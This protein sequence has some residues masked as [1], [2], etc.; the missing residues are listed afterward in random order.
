MP[1]VIG[2]GGVVRSMEV[3][4]TGEEQ[5]KLDASAETI[6]RTIRSVGY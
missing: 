6:R 4:L 2:A 3:P 1:A 5:R